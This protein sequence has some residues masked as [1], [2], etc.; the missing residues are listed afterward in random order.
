MLSQ[1]S[2]DKI[3]PGRFLPA[4][5]TTLM[6][7]V[8]TD[9]REGRDRMRHELLGLF[10]IAEVPRSWYTDAGVAGT[11]KAVFE[12]TYSSVYGERWR[13]RSDRLLPE[14]P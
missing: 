7:S 11:D 12:V 4:G 8:E 5:T 13:I 1:L 3:Q 14:E 2:V 6:L 10:D 9:V